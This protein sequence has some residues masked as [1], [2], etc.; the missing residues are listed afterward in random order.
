MPRKYEPGPKSC[1]VKRK[2]KNGDEYVFKRIY[3]YDPVTQKVVTDKETL[4]YK[5]VNGKKTE[6]RYAE[7][8]KYAVVVTEIEN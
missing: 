7:I 8:G 1:L 6:T 4:E 2:Q 5:I 3:H